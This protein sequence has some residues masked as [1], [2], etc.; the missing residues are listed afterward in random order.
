VNPHFVL[1]FFVGVL[2]L[3]Y[4]EESTTR[5]QFEQFV[6]IL[7]PQSVGYVRCIDLFTLK[8]LIQPFDA[9]KAFNSFLLHKHPLSPSSYF[10]LG[11]VDGFL[12]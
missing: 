5:L 11:I 7:L 3:K 12:F 6:L 9:E 10:C 1:L 2:Y 8:Q 4:F